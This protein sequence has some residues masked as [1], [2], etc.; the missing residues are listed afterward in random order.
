MN[1]WCS[2]SL[3]YA[4]C[5]V[6]CAVAKGMLSKSY[7]NKYLSSIGVMYVCFRNSPIALSP[8][9]LHALVSQSAANSLDWVFSV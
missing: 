1:V 8:I 7:Q 4:V 9:V 5:T 2:R 6:Y 3:S